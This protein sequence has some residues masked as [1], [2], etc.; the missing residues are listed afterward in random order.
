MT[1]IEPVAAGD[2]IVDLVYDVDLSRITTLLCDADGCLFASEE[3]AFEAS[4]EVVN[5][6]MARIGHPARFD[7][8][9]LRLISTGKSFRATVADLV[10]ECGSRLS[11]RELESWVGEEQRAVSSHLEKVLR[12][13]DEVTSVLTR[14]GREYCLA[15]V[16]SSAL[17]RL[18]ASLRS[19]G[20]SELL[21]PARRFSAEDSLPRPT[22]KPDPAIYRAAL[23]RL[24]I[25]VA[26]GIAI[27]DSSAGA[28]SATS[29][30]IATVGNLRFVRTDEREARRAELKAAGVFA[31]V[32]SWA[33]IERL[34]PPATVAVQR[35]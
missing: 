13:D 33:A 22:S 35:D 16:S 27:E 20:L 5:Q 11:E 8:E 24:G 29:A 23:E 9:Q 6:L 32:R 10:A 34:L 1:E 3:P 12:A 7:A 25:G 4:V 14:L 21:P 26:E 17:G 2:D 30:G 19:T 18:D 28:R 31:V 15:L